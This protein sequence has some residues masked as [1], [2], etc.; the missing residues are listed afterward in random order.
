MGL[1]PNQRISLASTREGRILKRFS[2]KAAEVRNLALS[3]DGLTLYYASS[4]A[5]WSIPVRESSPPRRLIDGDD[6]TADPSGLFL[7]VRQLS[8]D[9][10]LLV[11]VPVSGGAGEEIPLPESIH[12]TNDV[13]GS[14]SVDARGRVVFEISSP[15]SFFY[16]TGLY[17]PATKS[18]T[19]VPVRFDGDIW[20][21]IWAPDGRIAAIGARFASTIWRYRAAKRR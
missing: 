3:P 8:K 9:P 7:Y 5:V 21:P 11:R 17:D 14:N 20:S 12:F 13:M 19:A 15:D 10:A 1:P 16:R 6:V 4:G 18:V 2:I